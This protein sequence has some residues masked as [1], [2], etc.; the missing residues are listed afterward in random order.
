M[1]TGL[2]AARFLHFAAVMAL[3]GLAVFPL[4][5]YPSRAG[6]LP[7][8]LGQWLSTSLRLAVLLAIA[9]ALAWG[10]LTV[11]NMAGAISAAVD[12]DTLLFTLHETDFGRVWAAHL[13]LSA[14]LF[15]LMMG[16]RK[17]RRDWVTA[18]ASA[19][20]LL[21]LAFVGHTQARDDG[22]RVLHMGA[23]SAHLLAAG[24]WL[25]GLLALG[26][27]VMLARQSPSEH[28]TDA[29][30]AL[31]RF[32][33]IGSIVV[34][35]LVGS[36]LINA[37]FL[38]GSLDKLVTTP[39]G[40]LLLVKLCLLIGMLALAALNRFYLVPSLVKAKEVSEPLASSLQK[41]R[42]SVLGEQALGLTIVLIV[43]VLGA[44]QP[45][46]GSMQ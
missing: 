36:G 43:S 40:Q 24:A 12:L 9:S 46:I 18:S 13:V 6:E 16:R 45:A 38:V 25:G 28:T 3:F 37:W 22:L 41:L 1:E 35:T 8:R 20:L 32:S 2:I 39:Y 34:A 21:S 4:Y 44:M 26:Y 23:D 42:R 19:L 15:A 7:V 17:R 29:R 10:L 14:A 5:S 31:V 27:L 30:A 11:A 33:G